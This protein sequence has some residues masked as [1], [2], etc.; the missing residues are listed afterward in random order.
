MR[1]LYKH[2]KKQIYHYLIVLFL[3][4]FFLFTIG[5]KII[6]NTSLFFANLSGREKQDKS[7]LSSNS[8]LLPPEIVDIPDA[9][10]SA[11]I[12]VKIQAING[13]KLSIYVND[14]LQDKSLLDSDQYEADITLDKG[15]NSIYATLEDPKTKEKKDSPTYK[16]VYI[17]EKPKLE[18]DSPHDQ[19]KLKN[20]D[21]V[22]NGTTD[23]GNSVRINSAP[24]ITDSEGKFS[25]K[26]RLK[27]GENKITVESR[28]IAGTITSADL[29]VFY[30]KED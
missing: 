26:L 8:Y 5:P 2:R 16:V 10:S 14:I 24:A 7:G 19:D 15:E 27:S 11:Q 23:K 20:E 22:V 21:V 4:I 28:D 17:K 25:Y 6:I 30:E 1:R 12:K 13:K 18:I 9:T 3:V 29:T